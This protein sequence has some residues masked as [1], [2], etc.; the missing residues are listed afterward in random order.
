V[1]PEFLDPGPQ[2][3]YAPAPA[4]PTGPPGPPAPLPR[5]E[6][7]GLLIMLVAAALLPLLAALESVYAVTE[8]TAVAHAEFS[9]DAW[10]NYDFAAGAQPV[11]HAPRFGLVL[12]LAGAAFAI[13]ALVA[14]VDLLASRTAALAGR[15]TGIAGASAALSGLVVGTVAAM[16]L[17][18]QSAFDG[19]RQG[20][21]GLLSLRMRVG[22][23]VWLG[24]AGVL[25]GT[26]AALAAL[27]LRRTYVTVAGA[28]SGY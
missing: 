19:Y 1:E 16:A 18:I 14:A 9:V 22:A 23:S 12:A 3:Q 28:G 11:A 24:L 4:G 5:R 25:A 21:D 15:A 20:Y 27:R 2:Q 10:G 26:L 7:V 13:L 8:D 6:A 17:T